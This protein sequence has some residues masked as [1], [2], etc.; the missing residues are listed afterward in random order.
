MTQEER[1]KPIQERLNGATLGPWHHTPSAAG[2]KDYVESLSGELRISLQRMHPTNGH[3][4]ACEG[5]AEFIA[6]APADVRELLGIIGELQSKNHELWVQARN[7]QD[8]LKRI[9]HILCDYGYPMMDFD[10][11]CESER[12]QLQ[13]DIAEAQGLGNDTGYDDEW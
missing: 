5:T 6:H 12:Y 3:D 13:C 8:H 4:W 7:W 9:H 2:T 1:I 11:E 10:N